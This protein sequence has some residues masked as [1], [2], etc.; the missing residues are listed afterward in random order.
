MPH[1]DLVRPRIYVA[2]TLDAA[3]DSAAAMR[4]CV[5]Q[6]DAGVQAG[7]AALDRALVVQ[8]LADNDGARIIVREFANGGQEVPR[9]DMGLFRVHGGDLVSVQLA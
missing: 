7:F 3:E 1:G 8:R 9:E 6:A 4:E 5:D 2:P